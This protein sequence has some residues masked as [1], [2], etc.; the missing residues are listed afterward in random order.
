MHAP[1]TIDHPTST[2]RRRPRR[3]DPRTAAWPIGLAML[4]VAI[5]AWRIGSSPDAGSASS[6]QAPVSTRAFDDLRLVVP[7]GWNTIER[8]DGRITWGAPDR[9]HT[10]TLASTEASTLPLVAIVREVARQSTESVP[11]SRIVSGPTLVDTGGDLP[12]GDSLVELRLIVIEQGRQLQVVQTWRRDSRAG[13][14]IVAT[15]T[16]SDGAWPITPRHS[17]PEWSG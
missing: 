15:W 4:L 14:D 5:G 3:I 11:N 10:V 16:S 6:G 1:L 2:S 7:R 17:I 9:A 8:A 13:Y 12:R